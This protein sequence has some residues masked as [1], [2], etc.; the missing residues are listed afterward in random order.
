MTSLRVLKMPQVP[1]TF[2]SERP[3]GNLETKQS[4]N[5]HLSDLD[6]VGQMA[7]W[8]SAIQPTFPKRS[9]GNLSILQHTVVCKRYLGDHAT[10]TQG[11]TCEATLLDDD[12]DVC[13]WDLVHF[14]RT[15]TNFQA[16]VF[17]IWNFNL[18]T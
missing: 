17:I 6:K 18:Q 1:F 5:Y 13:L 16:V 2:E 8:L 3:N 7:E 10:L 14:K 4:L 15:S 9:N 11:T 12:E